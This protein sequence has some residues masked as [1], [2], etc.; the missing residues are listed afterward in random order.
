MTTILNIVRFIRKIC[1]A[2]PK[3]YVLQYLVSVFRKKRF[4]SSSILGQCYKCNC[5]QDQFL[6]DFV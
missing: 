2:R 4:A 1:W 5:G 3:A 6:L